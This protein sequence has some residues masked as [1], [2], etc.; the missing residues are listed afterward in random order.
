MA[1]KTERVVVDDTTFDISPLPLEQQQ[2]LFHAIARAASPSF[3]TIIMG[4]AAGKPSEVVFMRFTLL[5]IAHLPLD[6]YRRM[7]VIL[8][9]GSVIIMKNGATEASVKFNEGLYAEEFDGD[10]A[11]WQRWVM[12]SLKVN[13]AGFFPKEPAAPPTSSASSATG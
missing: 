9:D 5:V 12:E 1:R 11:H 2:E 7:G 13:F 4:M 8:R 10:L 6:V 3:E